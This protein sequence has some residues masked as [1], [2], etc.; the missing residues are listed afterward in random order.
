M[1]S[2]ARRLLTILGV[3]A[4]VQWFIVPIVGWQNQKGNHL[5]QRLNEIA[6]KEALADSLEMLE[7][8]KRLRS[9]GIQALSRL[10]FPQSETATLDIQRQVSSSLKDKQLLVDKFEWAPVAPGPLAVVRARV[11]VSGSVAGLFDW[12]ADLQSEQPWIIVTEF[13]YRHAGGRS[14]EL[15]SYKGDLTLQFVLSDVADD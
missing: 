7:A 3:L 9:D 5:E 14:L 12:I 10:A 13:K 4:L 15:D 8:E 6:G 1:S 2:D 11:A